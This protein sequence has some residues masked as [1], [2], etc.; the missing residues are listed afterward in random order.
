MTPEETVRLI[1][2][3]KGITDDKPYIPGQKNIPEETFNR[4]L[5]PNCVQ[6]QKERVDFWIYQGSVDIEK[7]CSDVC[8]DRH[9]KQRERELDER[10]RAQKTFLDGMKG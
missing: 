9:R 3:N 4:R 10:S 2:L 1:R 5:V 7:F 8:E 6:C